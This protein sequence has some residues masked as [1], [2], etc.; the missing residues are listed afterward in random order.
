MEIFKNDYVIPK[1]F[2]NINN[3]IMLHYG[4]KVVIGKYLYKD[5]EMITLSDALHI[6]KNSKNKKPIDFYQRKTYIW[7]ADMIKIDT[8][9]SFKTLNGKSSW[10][11]K[12]MQQYSDK[13]TITSILDFYG[14]KELAN[15]IKG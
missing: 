6:T 12:K 13:N 4:D 14:L 11:N 9:F 2:M 3:I 15:Y 10:S 8:G 5:A 1:H 7:N